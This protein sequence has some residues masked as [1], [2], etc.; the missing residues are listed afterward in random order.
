[1]KNAYSHVHERSY[2]GELD[3]GTVVDW[4]NSR[5]RPTGDPVEALLT[6]NA[7]MP[8]LTTE[9]DIRDYVAKIVSRSKLA[10][11]PVLINAG[12]RKWNVDWRLVGKMDRT[13]GVALIRLLHL[14]DKG[15]IDRIRNARVGHRPAQSAGA[16]DP[17]AGPYVRRRHRR[18]EPVDDRVKLP[19]Y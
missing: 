13:Q 5:A 1:M 14:A 4:L 7:G 17:A 16:P 8:A 10:V 18:A 12:P 11:A 2:F 15:L 6:M 19:R 3:A 9:H